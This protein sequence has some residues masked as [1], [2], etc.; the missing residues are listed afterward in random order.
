MITSAQASRV[1]LY[2][3]PAGQY[4]RMVIEAH[5]LVSTRKGVGGDSWRVFIRG[6]ASMSVTTVDHMNGTY[7]MSFLITKPG[8]Y[9]VELFLE[10]TLCDGYKEPPDEWFIRGDNMT[11]FRHLLNVL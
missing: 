6:D 4:S 7:E 10:Y 8:L 3:K 11:S 2:I 9:Y 1:N 5:S